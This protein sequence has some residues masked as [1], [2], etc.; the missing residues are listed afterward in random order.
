MHSLL[1][2]IGP[3]PVHAY[4]LMM[5]VAFAAGIMLAGRRAKA[6]GVP[7]EYMLDLALVAMPAG[8]LG[9]RAV[10]VALDPGLGW[11]D[12]PAIWAGGLSFH[13]GLAAA[14]LACGL[15]VRWRRLSFWQVADL[16]APGIALGYAFARIGCFLNGCCYG[17]PTSLPW[18]CRFYDPAVGVTPPSHPAQLYASAGS[19]L[20]MGILL[21]LSPRLRVRG[22]LFMS[23]VAL[24]GVLR[25][26]VEIF[27]HG[28][29][30]TVAWQGLTLAQLVSLGLVLAGGL[31]A[32]MLER[33]ARRAPAPAPDGAGGGRGPAA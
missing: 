9:A 23:Y 12:L 10:F 18:A 27:R 31:A 8:L 26:V 20:V 15:Y 1:F 11:R 19:L 14:V 4:G 33:R 29:T 30:S 2:Q 6:A 13:G 28:A 22:Q 17:T 16:V 32:W 21:W 25:F 24:Y 5:V 3:F 7:P